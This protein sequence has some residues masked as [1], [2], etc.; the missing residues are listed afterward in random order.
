MVS[1]NGVVTLGTEQISYAS[2]NRTLGTL[3]GLSK[4][5]QWQLI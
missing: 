1:V 4:R 2:V 5:V 3:S